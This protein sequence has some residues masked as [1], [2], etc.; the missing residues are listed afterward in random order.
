MYDNRPIASEAPTLARIP[1]DRAET[2]SGL[3]V[4]I[5]HAIQLYMF[6]GLIDAV[7]GISCNTWFAV[8]PIER[9]AG[10]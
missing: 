6:C 1:C 8:P 3:C 9:S 2:R 7:I 10:G 4:V 5:F